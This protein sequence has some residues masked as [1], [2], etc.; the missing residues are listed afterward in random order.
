[1]SLDLIP[2]LLLSMLL[3]TA[4]GTDVQTAELIL[5]GEHETTTHREALIV[6]DANVTV[7]AG[8]HVSG[9]IHVIGGE[10]RILG[11]VD[12]DVTQIA[13]TLYVDGAATINGTLQHIGGTLVVAPD[14]TITRRAS[15]ELTPAEAHPILQYLPLAV[16]TLLLAAGG[17]RLTRR[18]P[19]A[20]DNAGKA[21][22]AHPLIS[23]TIG[24]LVSVSFLSLFVFMAFTLILLP[25]SL[26]GLA[27]GLL[28][29]GYA[30]V[31]LG[32]LAGRTLPIRRAGLAT[33]IGVTAV[34]VLFVLGGA[35]PVIGSVVVLGL[36]LAG[37]GAV[38][39][40]YFGLKEFT[41]V[42]LPD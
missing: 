37:L 35:I 33:A 40:T 19:G 34:M 5:G 39:L 29:V 9:P 22:T 17:A 26:L 31:V 23:L 30:V 32:Y 20:L 16:V 10:T 7:P 38:V 42:R 24:A 2:M 8:E 4:G 27:A 25:V 15:V 6:G 36:L 12:G 41:P 28:T 21:I 1:M 18:R 14:A 3:M 11:T 13:G